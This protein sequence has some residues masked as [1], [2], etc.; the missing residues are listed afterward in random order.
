[1]LYNERAVERLITQE[2][3]LMPNYPKEKAIRRGID[4]AYGRRQITANVTSGILQGK[5]IGGIA[6]GL[7]SSITDMSRDSAIRAARTAVTEA[8]NAG[9][10]D[11]YDAAE[12]MGIEM[13]KVWMATLDD[14]T[15]DAHGEA[16]GQAVPEDEPFEVGGE[17]LMYPGDDSMG[18]SGWNIYNCRCTMIARVKDVPMELDRRARDEN[19]R[20][21]HVGNITYK[22]WEAQKNGDGDTL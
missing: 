13:E 9:R 20:N 18:A 17:Q 15:R 11:E 7:Q 21:V 12:E 5:S 6:D 8:E 10:Q 19:G 14:K 4:L 22:E 3:D 1:N 16:D 2:P